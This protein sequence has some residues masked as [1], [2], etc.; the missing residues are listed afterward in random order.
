MSSTTPIATV[1][2][3]DTF[4]S[5]CNYD[6]PLMFPGCVARAG[7]KWSAW[8][9]VA[10]GKKV[11]EVGPADATRG[12]QFYAYPPSNYTFEFLDSMTSEAL[13]ID[14][15]GHGI[16]VLGNMNSQNASSAGTQ[17]LKVKSLNLSNNLLTAIPRSVVFGQD[18]QNLTLANNKIAIVEAISSP[19]LRLLNLSNNV[20]AS[21]KANDSSVFPT[22]LTSLDLSGNPLVDLGY[23][24]LPPNL[25]ELYLDRIS[26]LQNIH[27]VDLTSLRLLSLRGTT[28]KTQWLVTE[29][30]FNKLLARTNDK[31]LTIVTSDSTKFET[32]DCDNPQ[33]LPA[34]P[35]PVEVCVDGPSDDSDN[36]FI[37]IAVTGV[38]SAVVAV[39]GYLFLRKYAQR[40]AAAKRAATPGVSFSVFVNH[41][42]RPLPPSLANHP[43]TKPGGGRPRDPTLL[44]SAEHK[45]DVRF[46]PAMQQFRIDHRSIVL[47]GVLASGGFGVV[48]K[49]TYQGDVVAVKQLLPSIDGNSDAVTDFMEEIRLCSMLDHPH[50]VRFIG[51]TWT[52]LKDVGAVME[53]M[54]NG[55]LANLVRSAHNHVNLVW[56]LGEDS[57]LGSG[58]VSKLQILWDVVAGL[59]YLHGF[60][61]IHRDLKA[62]N[63]LLGALY[64]AKLSDFGTSRSTVSDATM[65]A[66]VGTI[67]W[68]APEV[69]KGSKY[70]VSADMYSFGVLLSE[71]DTGISPY[72]HLV[73][74]GGSQ[75]PKPMIAMKVMDGELRPTFSPQCPAQVLAIA[76]RCLLHDP[77]ERP[78]A[79]EVARLLGAMVRSQTYSM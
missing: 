45:Y 78:T 61:V 65:T 9:D 67:A 56:S 74:N 57:S 63:V 34:L 70:A 11:S 10:S 7:S 25:A 5:Y 50:I 12:R 3:V 26:T 55:D 49:A 76:N 37:Y 22:S 47:D 24:L 36:T 69:L 35:A 73:T 33:T 27:H 20:L 21:L 18:L 44:A 17:P 30:H 48:H 8:I 1:F 31:T 75:L 46:D 42:T 51:V 40:R 28:V 4:T 71:V 62:K 38:V 54:P 6:A 15:A 60:H 64:Q 72:S 29:V 79:A 16:K 59:D 13:T 52:T 32:N 43:T 58:A 2:P 68:I 23:V 41:S 39:V 53:F 77:A 19:S 66:E 14:M